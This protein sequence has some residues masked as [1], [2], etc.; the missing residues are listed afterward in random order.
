[1]KERD[2]RVVELD[3]LIVIPKNRF[4]TKNW[5]HLLP[6]TL[7]DTLYRERPKIVLEIHEAPQCSPISQ[8]RW[9]IPGRCPVRVGVT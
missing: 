1:V 5:W 2:I 6:R 8:P 9:R 7:T 3:I 4:S